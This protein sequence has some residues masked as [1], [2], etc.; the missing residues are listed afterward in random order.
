M[1]FDLFATRRRD[2]LAHGW[3]EVPPWVFPSRTGSPIDEKN[4]ERSWRR[5]RRRAQTHG[6][7]PLK[8]HCTRHT[9]ASL[10]L[11]SGKS[12]RWVADQLGHSS[13]ALTLRIYAHAIREEELDLSFA[14]FGVDDGPGR[15]YTAPGILDEPT[16]E[17]APGLTGR[18]R[19]AKMEHETGLEPATPTLARE[20]EPEEP[21][22]PTLS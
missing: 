10:A 5:L 2:A 7:R 19:F 22:P 6:V 4:F 15:P 1:L 17:N 21:P 8:L 18:G 9:W 16:N 14:D 20:D 3:P 13:P 12:V 11:A